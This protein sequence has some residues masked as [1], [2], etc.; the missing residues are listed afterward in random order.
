MSPVSALSSGKS[1]GMPTTF[2]PVGSLMRLSS[3]F[4]SAPADSSARPLVH[5]NHRTFSLAL[6]A[7][8]RRPWTGPPGVDPTCCSER[9]FR[10]SNRLH[11]IFEPGRP[12]AIPRD[13]SRTVRKRLAKG[14]SWK[15]IGQGWLMDRSFIAVGSFG[16]FGSRLTVRCRLSVVMRRALLDRWP[17]RKA[18]GGSPRSFASGKR[19]GHTSSPSG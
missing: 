10:P 1:V 16:S 19:S 13:F 6:N 12:A 17:A 18:A 5:Y 14:T 9:G 15:V 11:R 7:I 4:K 8:H 3:L 2:I